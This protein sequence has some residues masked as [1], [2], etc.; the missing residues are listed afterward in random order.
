MHVNPGARYK[1]KRGL[2]AINKT[3]DLETRLETLPPD[4]VLTVAA[5][6][7]HSMFVQITCG[8]SLYDV[9]TEDLEDA[10]E[11]YGQG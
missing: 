7:R 1:L 6:L 10:A 2:T 9:A 5:V 8:T 11:P 4:T 3:N